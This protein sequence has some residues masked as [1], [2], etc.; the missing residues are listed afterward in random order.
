MILEKKLTFKND[1]IFIDGLWGTG[2]SMLGPVIGGMSFVEKFRLE[3]IFEYVSAS[4]NLNKIEEDAALWL[5]R[6][7]SDLS[8]YN[9][10]LSREVNLRIND[11][12]GLRNNPN[13]FEYL[14]RLFKKDG[15]HHIDNINENNIALNVM[16]HMLLLTP[17]L[18]LKA[19]NKRIKLIEVVRHPLYMI[20]HWTKYLERYDSPRE[21]TLSFYHNDHKI[22]WWAKDFKDDFIAYDAFNKSLLSIIKCYSHLFDSDLSDLEKGNNLL[23]LSFEDIVLKSE[24]SLLKISTFLK[25]N[26]SKKIKK[27]LSTQNIPRSIL[28]DGVGHKSYGW[29]RPLKNNGEKNFYDDLLSNLK[30]KGEYKNVQKFLKLIETYNERFPS[31]LSNFQ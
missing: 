9:N 2:K 22:P 13:S 8:Q 7:Y 27:I 25:R 23:F 30:K 1:I 15:D 24:D 11:D 4:Y 19:Y 16:S 29:K 26:H 21:F 17:E 6:T 18:L 14:L 12:S 20:E 5:L 10:L 3:H 28:A 31:Y